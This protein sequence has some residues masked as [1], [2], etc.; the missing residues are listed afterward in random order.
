MNLPLLPLGNVADTAELN[1]D[2]CWVTYFG[3]PTMSARGSKGKV[4]TELLPNSRISSVVLGD[5]GSEGIYKDALRAMM[6]SSKDLDKII[7]IRC[8]G[9]ASLG[10]KPMGT[11]IP[12]S[13]RDDAHLESPR[14]FDTQ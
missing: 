7:Q 3:P 1:K 10:I 9:S 14:I 5:V 13:M 2:S 8:R 12:G 6:Q 4:R 11:M